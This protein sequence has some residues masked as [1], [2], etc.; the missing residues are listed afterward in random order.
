[1]RIASA[2]AQRAGVSSMVRF[3]L[4]DFLESKASKEEGV[5]IMNPPYGERLEVD[6]IIPFYKEIGNTMKFNYNGWN[7]WIIS[8]NIQALKFVGLRPSRKIKLFNGPLECR[9]NKFELYKGS[10]KAVKNL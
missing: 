1:M 8:A 5:I 4:G 3:E 6:E 7:A 9:L 2:N 10:K